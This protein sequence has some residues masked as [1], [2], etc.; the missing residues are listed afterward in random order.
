[1]AGTV[2]EGESCVLGCVGDIRGEKARK[3]GQLGY[4]EGGEG[5]SA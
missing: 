2:C 3:K 5:L 4:K 1:M